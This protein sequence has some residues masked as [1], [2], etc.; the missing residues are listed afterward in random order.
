[1]T[2]TGQIGV[3]VGRRKPVIPDAPAGE[4]QGGSPGAGL[5]RLYMFTHP[6]M[7]RK[8][9]RAIVDF[10]SIERKSVS[11]AQ[12]AVAERLPDGIERARQAGQAAEVDA[13]F[14]RCM[15]V[16]PARRE[17]VEFDRECGVLDGVGA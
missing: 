4:I 1:M 11:V 8:V 10:H 16:R 3:Q 17:Q 7:F 14:A 12:D 2:G 6:L 13:A 15:K 9:P 5:G